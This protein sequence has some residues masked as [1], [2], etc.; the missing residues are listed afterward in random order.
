MRALLGGNVL[1]NQGARLAFDA[2]IRPRAIS[3]GSRSRERVFSQHCRRWPR[4]AQWLMTIAK[5]F[6]AQ[7]YIVFVDEAGFMLEPVIRRTWAPKGQTPILT[8]S[9]PHERISVIGAISIRREDQKFSFHYKLSPD[10]QNFTGPT[11]VEF[12]AE[13]RDKLRS[14]IT[15]IW[16]EIS[17]HWGT[18]VKQ[19]L[20]ANPSIEAAAF[21]PY[22]PELNPVDMVWSYVK[23]GRL[24]N[25][26]PHGLNE[27]RA[28][29]TAEFARLKRKQQLL[30]SFLKHTGLYLEP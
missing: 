6:S 4:G 13:M 11:V 22:A 10:N 19:F 12:V 8:I 2:V 20:N 5:S 23:Y 26:R 17:I 30:K 16:D 3:I 29:L 21:P 15:L 1:H 24:A 25:Y 7:G 14:P 28:T 9:Q 27:L 18:A